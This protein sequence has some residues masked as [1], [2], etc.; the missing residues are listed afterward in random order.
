[1]EL[2]RFEMGQNRR[3]LPQRVAI[4]GKDD[5]RFAS[6]VDEFPKHRELAVVDA[7]AACEVEDVRQAAVFVAP[8]E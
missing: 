2:H 4:L 1:M 8:S 7:D 6:F 5:G 3:Q